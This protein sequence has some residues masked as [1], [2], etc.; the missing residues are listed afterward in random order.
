MANSF[1]PQALLER[2]TAGPVKH[3]LHLTT[4]SLAARVQNIY[5]R[6]LTAYQPLTASAR[7]T[8]N[9]LQH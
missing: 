3:A 5:T 9:P 6:I 8:R 1:R 7:V 4:A 2:I